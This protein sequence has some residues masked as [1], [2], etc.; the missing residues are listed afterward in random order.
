LARKA[1]HLPIRDVDCDF[2]LIR[3]DKMSSF[4]LRCDSGAI[5]VELVKK[6]QLA[7][8]RFTEVA[9][10]HYP[11]RYGRSRFFRLVPVLKTFRQLAGLYSELVLFPAREE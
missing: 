11:R 5:C 2:R 10:T 8:C 4:Q 6:L 7:G 9:V 3:R 1:F